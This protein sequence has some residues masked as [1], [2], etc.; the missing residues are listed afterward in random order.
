[1]AEGRVKGGADETARKRPEKQIRLIRFNELSSI[2]RGSD[3]FFNCQGLFYFCFFLRKGS[4][5]YFLSFF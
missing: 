4:R 1:M 2:P 5:L 3:E